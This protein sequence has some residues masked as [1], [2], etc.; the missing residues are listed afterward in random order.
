MEEKYPR[1]ASK[2]TLFREV[3]DETFPSAEKEMRRK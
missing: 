3:W 1:L 2:L